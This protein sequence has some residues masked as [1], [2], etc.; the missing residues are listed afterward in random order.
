V[1][2]RVMRRENYP[3]AAKLR[4][5]RVVHLARTLPDSDQLR[6]ACGKTGLPQPPWPSSSRADCTACL[7]QPWS[8]DQ[9]TRP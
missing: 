6:T 2:V 3:L 5:G 4:N 9:R 8:Q 7:N 1:T